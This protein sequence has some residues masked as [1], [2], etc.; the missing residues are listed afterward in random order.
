[1]SGLGDPEALARRRAS[2][3]APHLHPLAPMLAALRATRGEVPDPDPLDGGAEARLLILLET[4]GPRIRATGIV[5][6]D[7]PTGTARN[8]ARMLDGAALARCDTL[9]WNAVPWVIHDPG[10]LNRAPRISEIRDG[11]AS[12]PPLLAV[13]TRLCVVVLAGRVAA[14]AEPLLRSLR[15]DLAILA[16]PHPS[17]TIQC[18]SPA[19]PARCRAVL[20]E[21]AG[22]LA[23]SREAAA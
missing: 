22:H 15:P 19:I 12:L 5:S 9:I 2:A 1:M 4:P 11:I 23:R 17:P 18:T 16:M 3:D 21:A 8:L 6:R 20:A 7:N 13:L 10:A 14:R